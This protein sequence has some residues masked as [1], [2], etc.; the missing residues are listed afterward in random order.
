[1]LIGT[2]TLKSVFARSSLLASRT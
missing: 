1:W 2:S